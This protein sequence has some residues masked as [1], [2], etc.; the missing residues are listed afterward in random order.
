MYLSW[1]Q[2]VATFLSG[3]WGARAFL[4]SAMLFTALGLSAW[5]IKV[6]GFHLQH[7]LDLFAVVGGTLAAFVVV[8]SVIV[9]PQSFGFTSFILMVAGLIAARVGIG[10]LKRRSPGFS[11]LMVLFPIVSFACLVSLYLAVFQQSASPAQRLQSITWVPYQCVQPSDNA[12]TDPKALWRKRE[13]V[14]TKDDQ[15][16]TF[17]YR[18][19]CEYRQAQQFNGWLA[20]GYLLLSLL[21]FYLF[22]SSKSFAPGEH[23]YRENNP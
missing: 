22:A 9:N 20:V 15:E 13:T 2:I 16:Y 11:A 6:S 17:E 7:F 18:E 3:Q 14:I 4:Y 21:A 5:C 19:L 8:S 10:Y 1:P 23:T 12:N